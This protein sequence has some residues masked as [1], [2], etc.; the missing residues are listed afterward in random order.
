MFISVF[1]DVLLCLRYLFVSLCHPLGRYFFLS[2][3][4]SLCLYFVISFFR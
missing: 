1:L 3:V 2:S 4:R